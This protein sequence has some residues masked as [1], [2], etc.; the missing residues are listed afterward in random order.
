MIFKFTKKIN[1]IINSQINLLEVQ[2]KRFML[3]STFFLFIY[4]QSF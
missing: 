4:E 1:N 2:K 3:N